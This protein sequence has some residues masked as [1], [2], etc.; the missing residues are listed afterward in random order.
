MFE[1]V[2]IERGIL[3]NR[4]YLKAIDDMDGVN[5]AITGPYTMKAIRRGF[6]FIRGS[7]IDVKI[8]FWRRLIVGQQIPLSLVQRCSGFPTTRLS[9]G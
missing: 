7:E 9:D 1:V 8:P 2:R 3:S 4:V 5:V 6:S